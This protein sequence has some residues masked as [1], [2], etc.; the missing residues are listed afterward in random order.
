MIF[1]IIQDTSK[2]I[3]PYMI[4]ISPFV[5]CHTLWYYIA[6]TLTTILSLSHLGQCNFELEQYNFEFIKS[7][8]IKIRPTED[9]QYNFEF[10]HYNFDLGQ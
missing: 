6:A 3:P 8:C 2:N 7:I 5:C 1:M 10:G 9:G 4:L